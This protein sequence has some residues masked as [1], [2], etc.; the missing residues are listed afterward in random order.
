MIYQGQ[1]KEKVAVGKDGKKKDV[2]EAKKD[3]E[4]VAGGGADFSTEAR[5]NVF[6]SLYHDPFFF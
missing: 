2:I 1:A 3:G 5:G 4:G 6:E